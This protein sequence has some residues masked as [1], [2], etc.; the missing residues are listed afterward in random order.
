MGF[1]DG[2]IWE[3]WECEVIGM[4]LGFECDEWEENGEID[5]SVGDLLFF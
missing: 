3:Y 2:W 1:G 4:E 5:S